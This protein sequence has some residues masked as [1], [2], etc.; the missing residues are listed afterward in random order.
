MCIYIKENDEFLIELTSWCKLNPISEFEKT[1]LQNN[2]IKISSLFVP[3]LYGKENGFYGKKHSPEQIKK[4]SDMRLGEKNPN[5]GGKAWTKESLEKLRRPKK[6]KENYKGSPGLITCINKEGK[7]V[8]IKKELYNIQKTSGLSSSHWEY[9]NTN[10]KEAK[11]R[12]NK[13]DLEK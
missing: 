11:L 12:K 10:S 5:Y 13:I 3:V 9:V 4:W 7:A 2:S 6:N 1:E 8:Q